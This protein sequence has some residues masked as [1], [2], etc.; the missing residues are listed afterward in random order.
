M[1]S[2]NM[3]SLKCWVTKDI[4]RE[5]KEKSITQMHTTQQDNE[6]MNSLYKKNKLPVHAKT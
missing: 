6:N 3:T 4:I 5:K 1:S 2:A